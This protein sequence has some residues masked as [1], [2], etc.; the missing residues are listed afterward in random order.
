MSI[1]II[2]PPIQKTNI[3]DVTGA[4]I[5]EVDSAGHAGVVAHAHS[6]GGHISF[7]ADIS[8]SEDFILADIS[9]T[10][11]YPHDNTSWLHFVNYKIG[12]EASNTADY[13]IILG[14]LE[15]VDAT[16]GDFVHIDKW[17]GSKQAGNNIR[18][19]VAT[20]PENVK[21]LSSANAGTR[22]LN[23]VAFQ[24]DVNLASSIDPTTVD[25]PSGNGDIVIRVI[26]NAGSINLTFGMVYHSH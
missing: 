6:E 16:N 2:P 12:E 19:I 18:E 3:V 13:Q 20:N 4:I 26:I 22:D 9:D 7:E 5:Q 23:D 1:S 14:F 8:V 15:N 25:T 24:T 11:N 21:A 10:T 17:N